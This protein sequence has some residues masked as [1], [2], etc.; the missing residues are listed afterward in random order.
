M[1]RSERGR[2]NALLP[3]LLAYGKADEA[4]Y[5]HVLTSLHGELIAQLLHGLALELGVVHLL[6]EQHDRAIP[7]VELAGDDLLA[8]ILGLL[9][10]LLLIDACL[11]IARLARNI[12]ARDISHGWRG[13]YLH[14]HIA[15]EADEILVG[16]DE[17]GVAIDLDQHPHLRAS[18]DVG[19]DGAL[20]GRALPEI[21]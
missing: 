11:A 19:L 1:H 5:Y 12:L 4:A 7:G 21:L 20:G 17:V 16:G 2:R 13:R 3:R 9:G 10:C 6:L 18:V 8:H 15:G 14:R